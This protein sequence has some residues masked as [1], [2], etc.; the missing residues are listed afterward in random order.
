MVRHSDILKIYR[1]I[2]IKK[3]SLNILK[4]FWNILEIKVFQNKN[5]SLCKKRGC[6]L[7]MVAIDKKLMGLLIIPGG[8]LLL[9][10]ECIKE[11]SKRKQMGDSLDKKEK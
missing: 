9:N 5:Q 1:T 3:Y 4:L 11:R 8:G 7:K 6:F 2:T 10:E